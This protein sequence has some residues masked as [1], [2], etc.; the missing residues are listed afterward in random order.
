MPQIQRG[1]DDLIILIDLLFIDIQFQLDGLLICEIFL[2][3]IGIRLN[4]DP[5][6]RKPS[7]GVVVLDRCVYDGTILKSV[8]CSVYD[9]LHI[10]EGIDISGEYHFSVLYQLK[11]SYHHSSFDSYSDTVFP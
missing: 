7:I 6:D 5:N 11:Q 9:H 10:A 4:S 2:D 1:V 8:R 3:Q